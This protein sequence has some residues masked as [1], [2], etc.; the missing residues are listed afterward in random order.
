MLSKLIEKSKTVRSLLLK[1]KH[2]HNTKLLH[3]LYLRPV[4]LDAK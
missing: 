2:A 1:R 4:R 3:C